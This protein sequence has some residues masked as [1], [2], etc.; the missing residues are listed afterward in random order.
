MLIGRRG[1]EFPKVAPSPSSC[2]TS[3]AEQTQNLQNIPK[4]FPGAQG[5][6][7]SVDSKQR[8]WHKH[9]WISPCQQDV[10]PSLSPTSGR[11]FGDSSRPAKQQQE[12][13][14][15]RNTRLSHK[16][17]DE[18][19]VSRM[20]SEPPAAAS[21]GDE[22]L[23]QE[24]SEKISSAFPPGTSQL[25]SDIQEQVG[26]DQGEFPRRMTKESSQPREG[27]WPPA[28]SHRGAAAARIS[29]A[30]P[31]FPGLNPS[32][33]P[34]RLGWMRTRTRGACPWPPRFFQIHQESPKSIQRGARIN[35][36]PSEFPKTPT[37][38]H[39]LQEI[40]NL[41]GIPLEL[42]G[43]LK[44]DKGKILSLK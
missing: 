17:Q 27:F 33:E 2:D 40:P 37:F 41:Q 6:D 39:H 19:V 35:H 25:L 22:Q 24:L 38:S 20:R 16:I 21:P 7:G 30:F 12:P 34:L 4:I 1:G 18:N 28:M 43:T 26:N 14:E 36:F 10:S 23:C 9:S 3:Q 29:W 42:F 15:M 31:N 8:T 32:S 13:K 5:S 11:D 44:P